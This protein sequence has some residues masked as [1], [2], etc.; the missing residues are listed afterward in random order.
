MQKLQ[1]NTNLPK[2]SEKHGLVIL[3]NQYILKI[4]DPL[5]PMIQFQ[6]S[7]Y[8]ETS[9]SILFSYSILIHDKQ[10]IE[11]THVGNTSAFF[12]YI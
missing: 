1:N 5:G 4:I 3:L 11:D 2:S 7:F 8:S 12:V 9:I 10:T 6:L